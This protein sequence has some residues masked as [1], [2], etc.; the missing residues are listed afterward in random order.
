MKPPQANSPADV[1]Y[2]LGC[3]QNLPVGHDSHAS[4]PKS[5]LFNYDDDDDMPS[6]D[7]FGANQ[8]SAGATRQIN[9]PVKQQAS[10]S[11]ITGTVSSTGPSSAFVQ[12]GSRPAIQGTACADTSSCATAHAAK[13]SSLRRPLAPLPPNKPLPSKCHRPEPLQ[14]TDKAVRMGGGQPA[15]SQLHGEVTSP[16]PPLEVPSLPPKAARQPSAAADSSRPATLGTRPAVQAASNGMANAPSVFKPFHVSDGDDDMPTFDLFGDVGEPLG[17]APSCP[18]PPPAPAGTAVNRHVDSHDDDDDMPTFDLFGDGDPEPPAAAL[19]HA[20]SPLRPAE[21]AKLGMQQRR[22]SSERRVD[23][24]NSASTAPPKR[25][26]LNAA[27]LQS[28]AF[29]TPPAPPQGKPLV[30]PRYSTPG[31]ATSKTSPLS[32]SGLQ[33]R[34]SAPTGQAFEGQPLQQPTSG[35]AMQAAGS[36]SSSGASHQRRSV[37]GLSVSRPEPGASKL[38]LS[39]A[40]AP[41]PDFPQPTAMDEH[42]ESEDEIEDWDDDEQPVGP[43]RAAVQQASPAPSWSFRTPSA[44]PRQHI[45]G[46]CSNTNAGSVGTSGRTSAASRS[47]GQ[48]SLHQLLRSKL[49]ANTGPGCSASQPSATPGG[50]V[51]HPMGTL[52]QCMSTPACS[53]NLATEA[54]GVKLY[55]NHSGS[56]DLHPPAP[57]HQC[58][59][60]RLGTSAKPAAAAAPPASHSPPH[61]A[62]YQPSGAGPG[63]P[64]GSSG[65]AMHQRSPARSHQQPVH[66]VQDSSCRVDHAPAH[67]A[68]HASGSRHFGCGIVHEPYPAMDRHDAS[69]QGCKQPAPASRR[70]V[71]G[72]SGTADAQ[73]LPDLQYLHPGTTGAGSD[74]SPGGPPWWM[75]L[76]DFVPVAA[77]AW[78]ENPR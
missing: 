9:V 10:F 59:P 78:G 17:A 30:T 44:A 56:S 66:R 60:S 76:P 42:G 38:K 58:A 54:S 25:S 53:P 77:L 52:A 24:Q 26:L 45:S 19:S 64:W 7:L 18:A 6:M 49:H 61:S 51:M 20:P 28:N 71:A 33:P 70:A 63:Q 62:S 36:A 43:S 34:L 31:A 2:S 67:Q 12:P 75:A 5:P 22:L 50:P 21:T 55:R 35:P 68:Q 65:G 27:K 48:G 74:A 11:N 4:I 39:T 16:P 40:K 73:Q 57:R 14:S 3:T 23:V 32:A 69:P 13:P 72:S 29:H 47:G 15:A 8:P 41:L 46:L 1:Q 37:L